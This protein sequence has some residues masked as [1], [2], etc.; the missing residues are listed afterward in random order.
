MNPECW[1]ALGFAFGMGTGNKIFTEM[2][3]AFKSVR[4]SSGETGGALFSATLR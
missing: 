1:V 2:L 3:P 4:Q